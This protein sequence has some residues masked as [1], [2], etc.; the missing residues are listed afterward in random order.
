[1]RYHFQNFWH[2]KGERKKFNKILHYTK[3]FLLKNHFSMFLANF[4][5]A[6]SHLKIRPAVHLNTSKDLTSLLSKKVY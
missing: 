4:I 2:F 1:M 6:V 5:F 3:R